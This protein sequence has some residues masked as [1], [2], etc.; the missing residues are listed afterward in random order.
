M[1]FKEAYIKMLEGKKIKRPHFKGYWYID[2][3]C[4]KLT[5]HLE[6][7]EEIIE[8]NLSLTV[9]NT[10]AED[11]EVIFEVPRIE[12][13]GVVKFPEY[14]YTPSQYY[15]ISGNESSSAKEEE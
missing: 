4:G 8:G 9:Q 7:G 10:L 14:F 5:I 1:T 15:T 2:G 11:W 12:G 13:K 3:V 6:S